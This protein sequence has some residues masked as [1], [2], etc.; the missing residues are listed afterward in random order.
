MS[1]PGQGPL[2]SLA[3]S[4]FGPGQDHVAE[5]SLNGKVF[6]ILHK[7]EP[8]RTIVSG[9]SLAAN[10]TYTYLFLHG[11]DEVT[12]FQNLQA[13]AT[14]EIPPRVVAQLLQFSMAVS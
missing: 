9:L 13:N 8:A 1:A 5:A 14:H 2:P 4:D 10:D 7:D 12:R 11:G 3:V 6:A